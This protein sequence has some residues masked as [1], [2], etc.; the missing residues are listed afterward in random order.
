MWS[1]P[2]D[3]PLAASLRATASATLEMTP[4]IG[5]SFIGAGRD[6]RRE[7]VH[8][9]EEVVGLIGRRSEEHLFR[10]AERIGQASA[11]GGPSLAVAVLYGA[12][13]GMGD[14]GAQGELA[15]TEPG[16]E[17]CCV[18][19]IAWSHCGIIIMV[20]QVVGYSLTMPLSFAV[21]RVPT[22]DVETSA[23]RLWWRRGAT[24]WPAPG[25]PLSAFM[26]IRTEADVV[27]FA[28]GRG[29]LGVCDRHGRPA[30][31]HG[32]RVRAKPDGSFSEPISGWLS[33]AEEARAV[34]LVVD[35]L[36]SWIPGKRAPQGRREP[37]DLDGLWA[38]L[39]PAWRTLGVRD[40]RLL[41]G[42]DEPTR[43][44]RRPPTAAEIEMRVE[45]KVGT[46]RREDLAAATVERIVHRWLVDGAV[47]P[48]LIGSH[49]KE[50]FSWE[51]RPTMGGP[52][53][54]SELAV[55]LM[56]RVTSSDWAICSWD[57]LD[58]TPE[59]RPRANG[60]RGAP[61]R[62]YCEEHRGIAREEAARKWR[63]KRGTAIAARLPADAV[64][65]SGRG[66]G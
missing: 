6:D 53:L 12:E 28:R 5:R 26:R 46:D 60:R 48:R 63:R 21:P 20:A 23:G 65:S 29:S 11:H 66:A 19:P 14:H 42:P 39:R 36:R 4:R 37:D 10:D 7:R 2:V 31:G 8:G 9:G 49:S 16:L 1:A 43:H 32:C 59:R 57:G 27:A 52:G 3:E 45:I 62:H 61:E 24:G 58:Y 64:A 35:L 47:R 34:L 55:G 54:A 41:G 22:V 18:D 13:V 30:S 56:R 15:K 38:S 25:D 44:R 51:W 50:A 33:L 40:W 17:T